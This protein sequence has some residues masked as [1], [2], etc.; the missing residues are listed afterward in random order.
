MYVEHLKTYMCVASTLYALTVVIIV[1][2]FIVIVVSSFWC[3]GVFVGE[4]SLEN[5]VHCITRGLSGLQGGHAI[6]PQSKEKVVLLPSSSWLICT[7]L[8]L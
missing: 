2:I 6:S 7:L 4:D 3:S 1:I 5:L 8:M